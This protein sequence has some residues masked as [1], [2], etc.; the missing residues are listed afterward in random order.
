MSIN[1]FGGKKFKNEMNLLMK[2][3]NLSEIT[4]VIKNVDNLKEI[5]NE[6]PNDI[7][8]ID[9]DKIIQKNIIT[10][11]LDFLNSKDSI[12]KEILENHG[13]D[14]MCFN[15]NEALINYIIHKIDQGEN[16][17]LL[18][19][20]SEK[21]KDEIQ[22]IN[23]SEVTKIDEISE[24]DLL[25]ALNTTSDSI[26]QSESEIAIENSS[27]N[28]NINSIEVLNENMNSL[29]VSK[30]NI[31]DIEELLKQLLNNKT[32]ELSIKIKDS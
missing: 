5:I 10:T 16:N 17:D 15:S 4:N 29:E 32:L 8:L 30:D 24:N 26:I 25:N 13:I 3:S 11:K 18:N 1:I 7:F 28:E 22:E 20:K 27:K 21:L 31:S 12:S 6:F 2:N 19:N 14:D 23:M 9:S